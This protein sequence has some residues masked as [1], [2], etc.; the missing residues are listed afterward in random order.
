[1]AMFYQEKKPLVSKADMH[2]RLA[3]P[4]VS[5]RTNTS[6]APPRAASVGK[7]FALLSANPDPTVKKLKEKKSQSETDDTRGSNVNT[8][9]RIKGR[10][11][12]HM[13]APV[14]IMLRWQGLVGR[15]D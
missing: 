14:E 10:I 4:V 12:V 11:E 15:S 3:D 5:L 13:R 8:N 7:S 6:W 9:V 1:M 2:N